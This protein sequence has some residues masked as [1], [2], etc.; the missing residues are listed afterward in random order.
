MN[1]T[2]TFPISFQTK[3]LMGIGGR[4]KGTTSDYDVSVDSTLTT[5][6]VTNHS[7]YEYQTYLTYIFI[8]Y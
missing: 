4:C 7:S 1:W 3:C 8:G 5:F 2:G 6:I